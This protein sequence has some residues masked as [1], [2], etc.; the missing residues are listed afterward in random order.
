MVV[1]HNVHEKKNKQ[2]FQKADCS[3]SNPKDDQLNMRH[4]YNLNIEDRQIHI[5][6]E[7]K[8]QYIQVL[9]LPGC[10]EQNGRKEKLWKRCNIWH[11][12]FSEKR[13]F[14]L[15]LFKF[16]SQLHY[17]N[18]IFSFSD[19]NFSLIVQVW[20]YNPVNSAVIHKYMKIADF[21]NIYFLLYLQTNQYRRERG[22]FPFLAQFKWQSTQLVCT[23]M[24]PLF[25]WV[26]KCLTVAVNIIKALMSDFRP[27]LHASYL[28]FYLSDEIVCNRKKPKQPNQKK[29]PKKQMKNQTKTKISMR[30]NT[31]KV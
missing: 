3:K 19:E 13:L 8:L 28:N 4:W 16:T 27:S 29:T 25:T 9:Y 20:A 31:P 23:M 2:T 17:A 10:Y 26:L 24:C 18:H 15:V 12:T 11:T 22:R 14:L 7:T 1:S 5:S 6:A 21:G 30:N